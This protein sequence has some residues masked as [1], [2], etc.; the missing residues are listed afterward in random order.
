M[1]GPSG[2]GKGTMVSHITSLYPGKFGFSISYTTRKIRGEE[3]NGVDYHFVSHEEFKKMI[4][5][6]KFIE[7]AQVHDNMYG[8]SKD[9]IKKIQAE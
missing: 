3:K 2:V 7:W 6:D 1:S 8:T 9:M 4:A 5:E